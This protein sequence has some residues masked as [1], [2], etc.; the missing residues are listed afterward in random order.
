MPYTDKPDY[1]GA[2]R[3]ALTNERVKELTKDYEDLTPEQ[4][5]ALPEVRPIRS[6]PSAKYGKHKG[7]YGDEFTV[8]SSAVGG[9]TPE[10]A[11][12]TR[13]KMIDERMGGIEKNDARFGRIMGSLGSAHEEGLDTWEL[14]K[15]FELIG[16]G[17]LQFTDKAKQREA[18]AFYNELKS[19]P[20]PSLGRGGR[21]EEGHTE[22]EGVG[23]GHKEDRYRENLEKD[24]REVE[25]EFPETKKEGPKRK[26]FS[27]VE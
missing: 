11:I 22:L 27:R 7:E 19:T 18:V 1:K 20:S 16:Q 9:E 12:E 6:G 21:L 10:Q 8:V 2:A 23:L 14:R 26:G 24:I 3:A 5:A 17:Q 25:R 13:E 4:E 15:T